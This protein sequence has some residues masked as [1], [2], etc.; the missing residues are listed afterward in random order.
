MKNIITLFSFILI[1]T[2]CD[3]VEGPYEIDTGNITPTDTNTYVKK[4]LIEDF[5]GHTCQNC[6]SAARELEAIHEVYGDQIIGLALHVSTGFAGPWTG[7]GKFEYDFRTK[8]G[9]EWDNFFNI[10][11]SGLP[12]GMVNRAGYPNLHKLGKNEWLAAVITELEK[13]IDFGISITTNYTENEGVIT[14]NTEILNNIDGDYNLVV[15]LS[16]SNIINWQKDGA[17]D[18]ENYEHNHALRS[19]L[20]DENLSTSSNYA[21]ADNIEKTISVN[22][23]TLEQFNINY[24]Q[25]TAELGNGNAGGWD[26]SNMTV[27]AYIYDN[28]TQEILQVEEAY[29]MTK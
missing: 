20:S 6:P 11:N 19:L 13:E 27:I 18:V 26:A 21:T 5:T 10:S 17:E 8:W 7:S 15:C 14:I 23:S 28:T 24:S 12:R 16:E 1:I 29:L 4:I 9:T 22:L 2:S 25:N 3:V